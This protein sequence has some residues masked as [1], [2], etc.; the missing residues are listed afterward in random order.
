MRTNVEPREDFQ[1][2][3]Q[4]VLKFLRLAVDAGNLTFSTS[5]LFEITKHVCAARTDDRATVSNVSF[6]VTYSVQRDVSSGK[7]N[8]CLR[9]MRLATSVKVKINSKEKLEGQL[10]TLVQRLGQLLSITL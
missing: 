4:F 7:R 6:A 2:F 1:K 3:I 8:D 10:A 5:V 9:E